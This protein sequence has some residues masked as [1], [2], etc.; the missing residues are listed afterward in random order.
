M[1]PDVRLY[2]VADSR[3][4]AA[5]IAPLAAAGVGLFQLRDR[6]L[7]DAQLLGC[8]RTWLAECHRSGVPLVINDR[9]DLALAVGADG[10]HLGQDDLPADVARRL[11]GPEMMI[12][13]STHSPEQV[14]EAVRMQSEG[15]IDYMACGPVHETPTKPGRRAAGIDVVVHAAAIVRTPWFAIGGIDLGN[16]HD[17]VAAG[18]SRIVVV[19]AITEAHDPVEAARQL[20]SALA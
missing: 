5:L 20:S 14:D 12:G 6:T 3:L 16:V 4:D 8:A 13:R 2:L 19:R 1:T 11:V 9:V 7:S 15:L 10:V 18:A 17:V